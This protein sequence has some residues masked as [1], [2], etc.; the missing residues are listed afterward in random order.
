[1]E[2]HERKS[3]CD[4]LGLRLKRLPFFFP[5]RLK[6]QPF[7]KINL[8]YFGTPHNEWPPAAAEKWSSASF[9]RFFPIEYS[10]PHMIVANQQLFA[11]SSWFL[12]KFIEE[13]DFVNTL[14]KTLNVVF[15]LK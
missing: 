2:L 11:S 8:D 15:N 3:F 9:S 12:G 7:Q 6:H 13:V 1:M 14:V 10:L 5:H 4:S